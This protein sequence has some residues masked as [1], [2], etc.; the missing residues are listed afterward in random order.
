MDTSKHIDRAEKEVAR[1]N[2][3]LAISLFDQI[4][5]LDPDNGDA[6]S[7]KRRAE[8]KKFEKG[9][10]S[11]LTSGLKNLPHRI[12]MGLGSVLRMHHMVAG[13]AEKAL[14]N[15]PRNVKLN[16][17]LGQALLKCGHKKGAEAAFAVVAEFDPND[18][19][20]LKT[21]GRLYYDSKKWDQALDCYERVLKVSPRD[22]VAVKM[23]KNLA[24]EGAIKSGGFESAGSSR[25]LARSQEQMAQL[26]KRQKIVKTAGD[27][28]SEVTTLEAAIVENPEDA[29]QHARLGALFLQQRELGRAVASFTE[30]QRLQPNDYDISQR[31]GDARLLELDTKIRQAKDDAKAG[32]DGAD[33]MMRRL[34][35]ERRSYRVDEF[36]RRVGIHPTDTALRHKLGQYLLEDDQIDEAIAEFQIVVKDPKRKFQ[37][38]TLMGNAFMKK[39]LG[40]LARKQYQQALEGLGG[41][42]EKTLDIVYGLARACEDEGKN[43]EA[44]DWLT[45]IFEIDISYRDVGRKIENLRAQV[46]D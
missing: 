19:E 21:L 7:G 35:R 44:L 45:R 3:D 10:P 26:E 12:A 40:D 39:G 33:D 41:V 15:D 36:R 29:A 1:R 37:A 43:E 27:L 4:L 18:V 24:A 42:N 23:R 34:I 6:R 22:Q 20:S 8:L 5:A 46:E 30:A 2:Y 14:G 11:A 16:L 32:E 25:D 31:L 28:E 17:K 38:M 9:Y 13:Q